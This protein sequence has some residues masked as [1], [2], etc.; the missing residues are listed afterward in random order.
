MPR[1]SNTEER[2]RQI[3]SGLL[4]RMGRLGYDGTSIQAIAEAAGLTPG[5]LHYHFGSKQEILLAL[6]DLLR[7]GVRARFDALAAGSREPWKRLYAFI[8]AHLA[9]GE[10]ADANAV[11]CWVAIGAE[12]SRQPAVRQA[13]AAAVRADLAALEQLVE[14]VLAAEGRRSRNVRH[15]AAG[16]LAAIHG[17]YQLAVSAQAAPEGFAAPT[18]RRM[19]RG[20]IQGQEES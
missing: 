10:G 7:E 11:A 13:Y 20:L 18:V 2:R 17:T 3:V 19:A 4:N 9:L 8:D 14:A 12:A 1:P 6:V 5:L 16:L 15:L